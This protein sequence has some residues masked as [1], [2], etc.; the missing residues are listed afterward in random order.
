MENIGCYSFFGLPIYLLVNPQHIEQVLVGRTGNLGKG[1]F[2][3]M[4][5]E[6]FGNGLLTSDGDFWRRQRRS[7]F[8]LNLSDENGRP[9]I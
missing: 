2:A 3:R 6:L 7:P 9:A 8:E 5:S 1:V 4:N